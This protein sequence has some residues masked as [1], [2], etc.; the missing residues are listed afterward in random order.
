MNVDS[1]QVHS[2]K[3]RKCGTFLFLG[4]ILLIFL[5]QSLDILVFYI[6]LIKGDACVIKENTIL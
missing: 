3:C 6:Y 4:H 5:K 2:K 1:R